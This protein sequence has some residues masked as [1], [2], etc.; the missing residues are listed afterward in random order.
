M[1][2]AKRKKAELVLWLRE[3][4]NLEGGLSNAVL[5]ISGDKRSSICAALCAEAIG[6][7]RVIGVIMPNLKQNDVD[8]CNILIKHLG[9]I[10]YTVPISV[11][12]ASIH[13]QIEHCG[14]SITKD[15]ALTLPPQIRISVLHTIAK[16][17]NGKVINIHEASECTTGY[18]KRSENNIVD[19]CMLNNINLQEIDAIGYECGLFNKTEYIKGEN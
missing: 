7:K 4:F 18:T 12:V 6:G 10:G 8:E 14:I 1:F 5:E 16:S 2:D 17:L 19:I 15:A 9:I 11:A 13:S 3:W